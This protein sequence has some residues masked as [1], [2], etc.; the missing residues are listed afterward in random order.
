MITLSLLG[1]DQ[2]CFCGTREMCDTDTDPHETL[3]QGHNPSTNRSSGKPY[4]GRE[5]KL[6]P[7]LSPPENQMAIYTL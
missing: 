2:V 1:V 5:H 3:H 7:F 4:R 6:L